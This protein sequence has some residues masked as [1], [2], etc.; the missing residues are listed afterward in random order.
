MY[1]L[2]DCAIDPLAG[3]ARPAPR[4][5]K[6]QQ[7]D[8][9]HRRAAAGRP[10]R[11]P[12]YLDWLRAALA[13]L[14][15]LRPGQQLADQ[16]AGR[17]RCCSGAVLTTSSWST[18]ATVLAIVLGVM[19]GIVSALRQYT[20]FDYSITFLSFLLYSLPVFWV[21][22]LVKVFLAIDFNDFLADPVITLAGDRIGA[23]LRRGRRRGRPPSAGAA[24]TRLRRLRDRRRVV[25]GDV[26]LP[27]TSPTGSCDPPIG[28]VA[29]RRSCSVG[30]AFVDH[31]CSARA[32]AT[33]GRCTA[34][35]TVA[36]VGRALY[37]PM[38]Y[39]W[40]RQ[41]T[42]PG[43]HR[44]SGSCCSLV[45]RRRRHRRLR[46]GRA[47]P[48]PVGAD[49]GRSTAI[50]VSVLLF[51]DRLHAELAGLHTTTPP[52]KGRPIA[53]FGSSTPNLEGNFWIQTIDTFTHL[54]LPTV[55]ADPHL[56]RRLHALLA[57][58]ML[59]VMNQ[60][61]IRTARSKGLHRAHRRHAA[62][63]P[64]R[65]AAARLHRADRH[66]HAHRRCG[67]H[68]DGLRLVRHGPAV[69]GLAR[70]QPSWTR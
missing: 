23:A 44:S 9:A 11:R 53:T 22:V 41:S 33:A 15:Q 2:V 7:I 45:G 32:C 66:H 20:G 52:I 27:A 57:G 62:R 61:Y 13:A 36:G 30:S 59:E 19:V 42:S 18:A 34:A 14:R 54:L 46:L 51:I 43:W 24:R 55:D 58:S 26:R 39:F 3:P 70:R 37:F 31:R 6:A 1:I 16:P 68:R 29:D 40:T 67:H 8:A 10:G 69:R 28:I 50:P 4:P 60:D 49:R 25:V 5:N 35:L 65:A 38:L 12:R 64:Q 63:L 48:E 56:V 17:P 21:A 47:R